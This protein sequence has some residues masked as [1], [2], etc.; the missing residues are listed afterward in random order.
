MRRVVAIVSGKGGVGK[1][2]TTANLAL[3]LQE[4]G[5]RVV[6]IDADSTAS[7]LALHLGMLPSPGTTLQDA[8]DGR[9]D[10]TKTITTHLSGL[11]VIPSSYSMRRDSL[12]GEKLKRFLK[13]FDGIVLIDTP[14]GLSEDVFTV[15][16]AADEVIV[17]TNPEIP[18]VADAIKLTRALRNIKDHSS[19]LGVVL[20]KVQNKG[21]EVPEY[22]ITVATEAPLFAKIPYDSKMKKS[23]ARRVPIVRHSPNSKAS[24]EYK[25][26]AGWFVG[27]EYT[28]P[29]FYK[30]KNIA[31]SITNR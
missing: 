12:D 27:K 3:A 30:I 28:P 9:V 13:K 21:Y 22:E 26:L 29:R 17:V 18:A 23:I 19:V 7:N 14:P 8:M 25:R 16:D 2:V 11:M 4:F 5:E 24:I 31:D 6:V 20:N 15:I 1:T 10:I